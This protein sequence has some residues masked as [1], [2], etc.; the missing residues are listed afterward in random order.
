[1]G[2]FY[3]GLRGAG[4]EVTEVDGSPDVQE[5]TKIVVSNGTLTDDGSGQVTI[6][7]GGGGG[8]EFFVFYPNKVKKQIRNRNIIHNIVY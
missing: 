1:M 7:T 6:T 3:S 5:V 4:L 2:N 8:G